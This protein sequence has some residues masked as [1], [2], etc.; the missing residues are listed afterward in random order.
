M[1]ALH[2]R[3][4]TSL[5]D[6]SAV[7]A[8]KELGGYSHLAERVI[9]ELLE[10]LAGNPRSSRH[11]DEL[12]VALLAKVPDMR[13]RAQDIIARTSLQPPAGAGTGGP[14]SSR[15]VPLREGSYPEVELQAASLR[16]RG[17]VDLITIGDEA[18]GMTDYKTG[19]P[20]P[21]HPDQLRIYALL[22]NHDSELNPNSFPVLRLTV[23]YTSHDVAVDPP[24]AAELNELASHLIA[25]VQ[26]AE[27]ALQQRPP[28][29]RPSLP[30]CRLCGVRQLCDAYWAGPG[31][32]EPAGSTDE[33]PQ[34]FDCEG[35]VISQNGPR[36]WLLA[37]DVDGPTLLLRTSSEA[38][39]L[40]TGSRIRALNLLR[41]RDPDARVSI[42]SMTQASEIFVLEDS[43]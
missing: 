15:R 20:K 18:C 33:E 26:A 11:V 14:S 43:S 22:W 7:S 2:A 21:D 24:S 17:R 12:R 23:S 8:L 3:N 5:A 42:G 35:T 31:R 16:F 32:M 9:A 10:P 37:V 25:R 30:M 36:S 19:A 27:T 40:R 39:V 41:G 28:A 13:Q 38:I 29:A 34:W 6:P 4:C 1:R